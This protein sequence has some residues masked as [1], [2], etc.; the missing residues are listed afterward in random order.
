MN[1]LDT[2]SEHG[3]PTQSNLARLTLSATYFA[4]FLVVPGVQLLAEDSFGS[5]ERDQTAVVITARRVELDAATPSQQ[6]QSV[7][8]PEMEQYG[9]TNNPLQAVQRQP[10]VFV[11]DSPGGT[12]VFTLRGT[13]NGDN[14]IL[15]DGIPFND[16][17][18]TNG[19]IGFAALPGSMTQRVDILKGSQPIYGTRAV[20]GVVNYQVCDQPT[21]GRLRSA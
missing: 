6:V 10:G 3:Y 18:S 21:N 5:D 15:L 17:S 9:S 4:G 20:G 1:N 19:Q 14:Q 2:S 16:G 12:S 11:V 8:L 13:A 7:A